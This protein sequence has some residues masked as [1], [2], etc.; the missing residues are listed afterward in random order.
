MFSISAS[1]SDTA[2]VRLLELPDQAIDLIDRRR[3]TKGHGKAL[4][5]EPDH[6]RRRQLARCAAESGWSVRDLEAE[7]VRGAASRPTRA[8]PHPDHIA[9][10]AT[11][12]ETISRA[13]GTDVQARPHRRGFQLLLDQAAVHRL[14][15]LLEP[16][17]TA[18]ERA[19]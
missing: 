2:S 13:L 11:L 4:L 9:A 3:L 7:I 15:Q 12:E 1:S 14:L 16:G 8:A 17:C 18:D 10:A 19:A 5:T 6:D